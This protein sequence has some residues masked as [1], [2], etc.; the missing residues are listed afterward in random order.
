MRLFCRTTWPWSLGSWP[1]DSTPAG[2]GE[3]LEAK[4]GQG[5]WQ[6]AVG[7][8]PLA[9]YV[10]RVPGCQGARRQSRSLDES[11][12]PFRSSQGLCLWRSWRMVA[13]GMGCHPFLDTMYTMP[14]WPDD[15]VVIHGFHVGQGYPRATPACPMGFRSAA[16]SAWGSGAWLWFY[17]GCQQATC[18][19]AMGESWNGRS[20]SA[21]KNG[22][23]T[24]PHQ[25]SLEV[26]SLLR[27]LRYT[28]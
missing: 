28:S 18:L 13:F 4:V 21:P 19:R 9:R 11:E 15:P 20:L 10:L 3:N 27:P 24:H 5:A 7:Y 14:L 26:P 22:T 6:P 1:L 8:G 25:N 23:K 2:A 17:P 12:I 16:W